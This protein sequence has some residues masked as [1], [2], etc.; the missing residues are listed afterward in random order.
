MNDVPKQFSELKDLILT[1]KCRLGI[2]IIRQRTFCR[3]K[4]TNHPK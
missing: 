4:K 3:A 1:K 2:E